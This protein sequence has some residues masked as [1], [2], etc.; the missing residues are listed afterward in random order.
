MMNQPTDSDRL[1]RQNYIEREDALL[2]AIHPDD[3][4]IL[5]NSPAYSAAA[6]G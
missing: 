3:L 1:A 2:C 4:G 6:H 5:L